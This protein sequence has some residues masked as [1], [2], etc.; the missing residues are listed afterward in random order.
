MIHIILNKLFGW[1][2][3]VW[4]NSC[5]GGIARVRLDHNNRVWYWRYKSTRVR[6]II[7]KPSEVLWI[8]CSPQKYFKETK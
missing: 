1:D 6:D 8:T 4:R 5:D 7:Q 3:I 2:Y